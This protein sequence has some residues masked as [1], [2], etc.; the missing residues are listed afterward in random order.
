MVLSYI[1]VTIHQ[2]IFICINC[3]TLP[4]PL[5]GIMSPPPT[6]NSITV[7][8]VWFAIVLINVK[9]SYINTL[10]NS[11]AHEHSISHSVPHSCVQ[12]VDSGCEL[13]FEVSGFRQKQ[14][15]H[16]YHTPVTPYDFMTKMIS[17][18]H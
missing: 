14:S 1:L 10:H 6:L 7:P 9:S 4:T 5:G 18:Q 3:H 8:Y 2:H 17:P 12:H 16:V 11:L 15:T 13:A